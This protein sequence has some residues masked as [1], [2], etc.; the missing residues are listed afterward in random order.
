MS[1]AGE[2]ISVDL[3]PMGAV[4]LRCTKKF[5]PRRKKAELSPAAKPAAKRTSR[6]KAPAAEESSAQ[7]TKRPARKPRASKSGS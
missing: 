1:R 7:E 4:I 6:K 3:P 5:P 2:S